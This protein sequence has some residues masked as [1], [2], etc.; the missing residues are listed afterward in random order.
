M[1]TAE[2]QI[3][4]LRA[5]ADQHRSTMHAALAALEATGITDE[6]KEKQF[7]IFD[8]AEK[9][10][11]SVNKQ[12]D[13]VN[14]MQGV[15]TRETITP[16]RT[17]V[18]TPARPV[19]AAAGKIVLP[20]SYRRSGP[21]KAFKGPNADEHAYQAGLWVAATMYKSEQHRAE[22]EERYGSIQAAMTTTN[23]S[24][25][26]YFVPIQ[27]EN[28]IIE[29]AET[30]GV[31]RRYAETVS[32][33]SD[34]IVEPRWSGSLTAYF[35]E[36]GRAPTESNP[37]WDA[38]TIN[39]KNLAAFG[40][41]SRNLNEDAII[42]L[43]DKWAMAAAIAF[44]EKEDDCGFNGDG[45]SAYGGITGILA[46]LTES[47][48]AAAL[49]IATGHTTLGA[50]TVD[51]FETVIGRM[52]EYPGISPAW[53]C[54]KEVYH[55]TMARLKQAAGGTTPADLANGGTPNYGGYPVVF[56]QKMPKASAVTSG[57]TGIVFGDLSMSSKLGTRRGTTFETG[58]DGNDFSQ[59]LMSL[60]F[61]ERFGITNH[62]IVD[63]RNSSAAG[64][65]I[66][67]KLG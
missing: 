63:P 21:L 53:F 28:T 4:K 8:E 61:T 50:L 67:L 34:T 18:V 55:A 47:A 60:L 26:A 15:D 27:M 20:A 24:S 22:Y 62:T 56:T 5:T 51:D 58:L 11:A 59:Q 14:R 25:A 40:K 7:A 29:L 17:A 23:N 41:M 16:E 2:E 3:V 66:G 30:F 31:F 6:D 48:N 13:R 64:P 65:V 33:S 42:N 19:F 49:V 54:H 37:T 9:Q 45:T 44:A 57:V 35:V 39:A 52:P 12:I 1:P 36:E 38:V 10:L 32:M 46:K 43:G